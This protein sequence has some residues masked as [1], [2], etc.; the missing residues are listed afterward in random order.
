MPEHRTIVATFTYPSREEIASLQ[1]QG[2]PFTG[3]VEINR[4]ALLPP[5][6]R[7]KT[8]KN[9]SEVSGNRQSIILIF[10]PINCT[11]T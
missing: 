8:D 2:L 4:N 1:A 10:L 5:Y 9:D 6:L 11:I 7:Q 3:K